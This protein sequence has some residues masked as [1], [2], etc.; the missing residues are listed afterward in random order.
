MTKT[1]YWAVFYS[2]EE[3]PNFLRVTSETDTSVIGE[4]FLHIDETRIKSSIRA[5]FKSRAQA[6][7]AIREVEYIK[8]RHYP[9]IDQC[10]KFLDSACDN[11]RGDI[12]KY[13][14]QFSKED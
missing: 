8:D 6:L 13:F 7:S 5:R 9:L 12:D 2:K 1:L 11:E 10:L 14:E 3:G 4:D